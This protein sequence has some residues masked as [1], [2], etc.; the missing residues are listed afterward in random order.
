MDKR[1]EGGRSEGGEVALNEKE[2]ARID[3]L[4]PGFL[5]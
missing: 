4:D 2:N 5:F 3:F 1:G